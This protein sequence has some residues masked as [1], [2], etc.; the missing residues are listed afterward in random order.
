MMAAALGIFSM[1]TGKSGSVRG[2]LYLL[3]WWIPAVP[4]QLITLTSYRYYIAFV[5]L[6]AII[7]ACGLMSLYNVLKGE[8]VRRYAGSLALIIVFVSLITTIR[9]GSDPDSAWV[10][11][12][13]RAAIWIKENSS[14]T[15]SVMTRE[16]YVAFFAGG[17]LVGIP[18]EPL[19]KVLEYARRFHARFLVVDSLLTDLYYPNLTLLLDPKDAPTDMKLRHVEQDGDRKILVYGLEE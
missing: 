3:G 11:I 4:L 7:M 15:F 16:P 12:Q 10:D 8:H 19:P 17:D 1:L 9:Y 6:V 2:L 5:P 14:G 13:R 18:A